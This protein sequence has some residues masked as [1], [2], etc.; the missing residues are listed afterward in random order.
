M[1]F[2]RQISTHKA[3]LLQSQVQRVQRPS[4]WQTTTQKPKSHF[5]LVFLIYRL[6]AY[7]EPCSFVVDITSKNVK[8]E[9]VIIIIS[10][11]IFLN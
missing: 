3:Y 1:R 11:M 2:F 8:I 7:I 9:I 5:Q 4:C 6:I 10:H